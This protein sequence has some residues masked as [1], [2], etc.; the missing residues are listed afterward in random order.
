MLFFDSSALVKRYVAEQ[1]S[2]WVQAV[3]D[4]AVGNTIFVAEI[5][6]VEVAAAFAA[7][8]R[9]PR[10]ILQEERDR[11]FALL[12]AHVVNE[13]ARVPMPDAL[14]DRAML[15]TQQHR[16]R[17]YDAVQLAAALATNEAVQA[18]GLPAIT[19]VSA[20]NDLLAAAQAE[21]IAAENPNNH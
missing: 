17:G 2:A 12:T 3:T 13:Y 4:A 14:I 6:R 11:L 15:L 5:T 10:G 21:G 16:L 8:Q 1:G 9:A 20:D 18:T 19:F 7:R